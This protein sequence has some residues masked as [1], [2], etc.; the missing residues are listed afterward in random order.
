M[1]FPF[2]LKMPNGRRA[3]E[4]GVVFDVGMSYGPASDIGAAAAFFCSAQEKK[5]SRVCHVQNAA[6]FSASA[7]E[8][9]LFPTGPLDRDT[10]KTAALL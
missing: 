2:R 6:V 3:F 10:P 9:F 8:S 4:T 1:F 7:P 5:P